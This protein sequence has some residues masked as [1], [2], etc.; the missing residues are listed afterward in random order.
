MINIQKDYTK[1]IGISG[2][3]TLESRCSIPLQEMS[4]IKNSN[5]Q[6]K[7]GGIWS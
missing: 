7:D 4:V 2:G 6:A 3:L 5:H 1:A